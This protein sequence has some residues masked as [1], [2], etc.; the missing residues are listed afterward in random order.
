MIDPAL[1]RRVRVVGLDVDGVLTD[2]AVY[3]GV[4]GEQPVELK[5]F[6]ILDGIGIRLLQD[7]GLEVV[8]ISG[9]SSPATTLRARELGIDVVVQDDGARKWPALHALLRAR[10]IGPEE[11]AFLGDDLPD[12]PV[13]ERVGLPAA[14][15]N[16]VPEVR[17][18]ASYVTRALGG[19]GAVREFAQALLEARGEWQAAVR[20]YLA[21]RTADRPEAKSGAH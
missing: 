21:E 4:A 5:Q 19:R 15:G 16:A 20:R 1:A 2:G 17:A 14:V 18:L 12:I 13:L 8:I 11:V 6:D 9:R 10:G 3:L 7:A